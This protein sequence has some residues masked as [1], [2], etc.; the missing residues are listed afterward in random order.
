LA[1]QEFKWIGFALIIAATLHF[2]AVSQLG[3]AIGSN[4]LP[5]YAYIQLQ[6]ASTSQHD[7]RVTNFRALISS[8][9]KDASSDA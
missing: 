3:L 1:L 4:F 2:S 9:G 8:N 6:G 7:D 5:P